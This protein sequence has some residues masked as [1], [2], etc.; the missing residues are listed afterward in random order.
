ME[1]ATSACS[2]SNEIVSIGRFPWTAQTSHHG[3]S[4]CFHWLMRSPASFRSLRSAPRLVDSA[5]ALKMSSFDLA[6][7]KGAKT[8]TVIVCQVYRTP[9]SSWR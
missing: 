9:R 6:G 7:E 2:G 4:G 3:P 8:S 1:R 5:A